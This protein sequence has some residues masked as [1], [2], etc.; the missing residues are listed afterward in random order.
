[1][2]NT[3]G[4]TMRLI[5]DFEEKDLSKKVRIEKNGSVE[6]FPFYDIKIENAFSPTVQFKTW[7]NQK[8]RFEFYKSN[9]FE[10]GKHETNQNQS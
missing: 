2:K 7:Q 10:I 4:S 6:Y 1:M 5:Y 8:H 9:P 3:E